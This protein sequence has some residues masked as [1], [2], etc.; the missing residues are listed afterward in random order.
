M[1]FYKSFLLGSW[2]FRQL[3]VRVLSVTSI[4]L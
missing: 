3:V 1:M 2:F 4:L